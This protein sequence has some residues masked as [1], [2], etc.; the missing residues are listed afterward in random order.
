VYSKG[1]K[2]EWVFLTKSATFETETFMDVD[3]S[4]TF[5]HQALFTAEGM[6][7]KLEGKGSQYLAAY[8]DGN[9]N[10]LDGKQSYRLHVD[11]NVPVEDSWSVMVYDAESRS[12]ILNDQLPGP[13]SNKKLDTNEDGSVDLYFGPKS[14]KGANNNWIK[15]LPEQGFFLYF[16]VYGPKKEFNDLRG[17]SY[18]VRPTQ[19]IVK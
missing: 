13:D 2:W 3:A 11:A 15:T 1:A 7:Q 9:G 14:P 6:V 18:W 17:A 4:V 12:M 8:K 5:S 16:R 10:W 19:P